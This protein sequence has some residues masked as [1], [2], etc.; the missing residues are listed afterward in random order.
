MQVLN[1]KPTRILP[2]YNDDI[3]KDLDDDAMSAILES[4][5]EQLCV[6][7]A[8]QYPV[9]FRDDNNNTMT[10]EQVRKILADCMGSIVDIAA[11]KTIND[12]WAKTLSEFFPGLNATSVF[13][14]QANFKAKMPLP[15]ANVLYTAA[16]INDGCKNLLSTGDD[17]MLVANT[18]FFIPEPMVAAWFLSAPVFDG[19][20]TFVQNTIQPMAQFIS[21]D[22]MNKFNGLANMHL[23]LV[24]GLMLRNNAVSKQDTA[25]Y[26]FSRIL[27]KLLMLYAQQNPG[28]CGIIAPYVQELIYPT[29]LI[30]FDVDMIA[31]SPVNK[32]DHLLSDIKSVIKAKYKPIGLKTLAKLSALAQNQRIMSI[33]YNMH[34]AGLG[35]DPT[36]KRALFRFAKAPIHHKNLCKRII[37]IIEKEVNVAASENY[38]KTISASYMRANRRN[39]DNFN[40]PGKSVRL[41]Y[42]PDIHIYLDT[43]G[44][45][46]EENYKQAILTCIAMAKKLGINLYFNSFSHVISGC[47]KLHLRGKSAAGIYKEFQRIPK[48]D[49]GT[50]FTLVWDYICDPAHSYRMREISIMITDFGF[51][52]PEGRF[53]YPKKMYY[54]PIDIT[55]D[56]WKEITEAAQEFCEAMYAVD[57][58]I[59]SKILM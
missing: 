48:V 15:S 36:G 22:D 5:I 24:E 46:D 19:F 1:Q 30:F 28:Q 55:P 29:N 44:S 47:A 38:S 45:I 14:A 27:I 26:A 50:D 12:L 21:G 23:D 2:F 34:T 3:T 10:K 42:K 25:P 57:Q 31:K 33:Q 52:V 18:G 59:R 49:G 37:K 17:S 4:F 39:P 40:L 54:V 11:E 20:K 9:E 32:L 56:Y 58:K 51:Y 43:S 53:A 6:P 7:L 8:P 35:N 13:L 41:T 16:D